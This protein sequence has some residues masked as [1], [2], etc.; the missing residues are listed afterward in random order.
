MA[1]ADYKSGDRLVGFYA[2]RRFERREHNGKP[3]LTLNLGDKTASVNAV[4]WDSFAEV[5]EFLRQGVVLKIQGLMSEYRGQPQ[6]RLERIRVAQENEYDLTELLPIS[7]VPAEQLA[8]RLDEIINTITD[9]HLRRV[10]DIVFAEDNARPDFLTTP[11][12]QRWHHAY[13]GG[14][15]EH[16]YGVVDICEFC[17]GKYAELNRDLLICGALVHDIGKIEQYRTSSVFEYT[18]SGRLLGHIVEGDEIVS[19]AIGQIEDFPRE[20]ELQLRHLVLS[21]Q[22]KHEHASPVVPMTS[23]AFILYY[24]D[25]MDSMLGAIRKIADKTG[26]AGWSEYVRLIDRYIYFSRGSEAPEIAGLEAE[27]TAGGGEE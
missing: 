14:L 23:E 15:A 4:M 18:D 21:H 22:G 16:T 26:G 27:G 12:G 2:V 19:D 6:I 13:I 1:L 7:A 9:P 24:A 3:Y 20:K 10:M 25:E 5:V 17:A 8:A 11:G